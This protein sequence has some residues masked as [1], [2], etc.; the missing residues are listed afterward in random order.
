[1]LAQSDADDRTKARRAW[2][3]KIRAVAFR[4]RAGFDATATDRQRM[5]Y[6]IQQLAICNP[7]AEPAATYYATSS[8]SIPT[9][10][11]SPTL[12]GKWT[13]IYTDAPDIL[14]L[15][16]G[17]GGGQLDAIGQ[18]CAPPYIRNVIAW[19]RPAWASM[20]ARGDEDNNNNNYSDPRLL[21]KVVTQA[22]AT[23]DEPTRVNLVLQG[24]E[25]SAAE[26]PS[27]AENVEE[28]RAATPWPMNWLLSQK[29]LQL[30][31]PASL[32]F[33]SFTI[34]YLDDELRIVRTNSG[35]YAMNERNTAATEWF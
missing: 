15:A 20:L 26:N 1:L 32:P 25:F 19:R 14:S 21:Q 6:L 18:E 29:S 8:S 9:D 7:T 16:N 13:L 23:P 31:G 33:G 28:T 35:Y 17:G 3:E 22:S 30:S 12:A 2:K 24:L 5:T 10:S 27:K 34:L 4:T 11:T